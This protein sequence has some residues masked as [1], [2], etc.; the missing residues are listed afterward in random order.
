[1]S[2]SVKK[3]RP[4]RNS[5][6]QK[7]IKVF[8]WDDDEAQVYLYVHSLRKAGQGCVRGYD[9]R[10]AIPGS[11]ADIYQIVADQCGAVRRMPE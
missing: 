10:Y 6:G 9:T 7:A 5:V 1:V 8:V 11:I 3:A 4:K 2:Q